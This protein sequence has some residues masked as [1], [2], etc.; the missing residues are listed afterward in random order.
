VG[1]DSSPWRGSVLVSAG[2]REGLRPGLPALV[3]GA[4]AGRA[5]ETGPFATRVRL[6]TDP[7]Q[8]VWAEIVSGGAAVAGCVVGTGDTVLEMAYARAGVGRPGDPVFTAVGD[9][10]VPRGLLIG[11]VASIAD[12][13]RD[14][15]A[16]VEIEPAVRPEDVRYLHV[17]V[18]EGP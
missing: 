17:L 2:T 7:G 1:R 18:P 6:L 15:L 11:K 14:G 4:L 12:A 9:P 3:G 13:D 10:L 8:R 16:E 5:A